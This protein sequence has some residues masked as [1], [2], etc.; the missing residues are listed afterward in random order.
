MVIK[1]SSSVIF[2]VCITLRSS[3]DVI[4]SL[5]LLLE[6]WLLVF[7]DCIGDSEMLASELPQG[8]LTLRSGVFTAAVLQLLGIV[9]SCSGNVSS[10]VASDLAYR[11]RL[12]LGVGESES[13]TFWSSSKS[14]VKVLTAKDDTWGLV[15]SLV[16]VSGDKTSYRKKLTESL[17]K[18]SVYNVILNFNYLIVSHNAI[19]LEIP[20]KL[21]QSQVWKVLHEVT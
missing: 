13:C 2:V 1:S 10:P 6:L 5:F 21:N 17:Y 14:K 8:M 9:F 15:L 18:R 19:L 7:F 4:R 12:I 20:T 16:M 11:M 3:G